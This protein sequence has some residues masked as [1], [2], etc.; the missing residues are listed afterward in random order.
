MI[1]DENDPDIPAGSVVTA[2]ALERE[3][4][5]VEGVNN[6][7]TGFNVPQLE[8]TSAKIFGIITV[9]GIIAFVSRRIHKLK[10]RPNPKF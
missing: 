7:D 1:V 4:D 5:V 6:V 10:F 3:F 2:G 9:G 8:E